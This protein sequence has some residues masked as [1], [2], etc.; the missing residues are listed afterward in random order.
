MA[1]V[2]AFRKRAR[3]VARNF[4]QSV[5]VV[6]DRA[7][8]GLF[9][10]PSLA[11]APTRGAS[12]TVPSNNSPGASDEQ[13]HHLNAKELIDSFASKGMVCSVIKPNVDEQFLQEAD[14]AAQR[15]DIVILDWQIYN[16]DGKATLETIKTIISTDSS[17]HDRLRLIAIYTGVVN[18]EEV[19][20]KV[21]I[22]LQGMSEL[23]AINKS[24]GGFVFDIGPVRTVI[25]AKDEGLLAEGSR[26]RAVSVALLADTVIDEFGMMTE[27][28][29]PSAVL[30]AI[31]ELRRVT[32][33]LISK[34]PARLDASYLNHRSLTVPADEALSHIYPLIASEIESIL[35]DCG[36]EDVLSDSAISDWIDDRVTNG[37]ELHTKAKI[38]GKHNAKMAIHDL[39]VHGVQEAKRKHA[40]RKSFVKA[41]DLIEQNKTESLSYLTDLLVDETPAVAI[42]RDRELAMRMS[43]RSRYKN[44]DPILQLGA[45]LKKKRSYYLCIQ[46]LCDCARVGEEMDF[47]FLTLSKSTKPC[48]F[49][50]ES[51]SSLLELKI[52]SGKNDV[53]RFRF[54]PTRSNSPVHAEE[55]REGWFFKDVDANEYRWVCDLKVQHA[56]RV[57]NEYATKVSRVGL[58]ESEWI[59]R[60]K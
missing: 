44:P 50:V 59:R 23:G 46:P 11:M 40:T 36:I 38:R 10:A 52:L 20:N 25:Y 27:G 34:F 37:V 32:H 12:L 29:L 31:G 19:A 55:D 15:A 58:T 8:F 42:D 16:D 14:T 5:V 56:Q 57:A 18:L 33:R 39:I 26:H 7:S 6:D 28:L 53:K 17:K 2:T 45:V 60:Q 4:L 47:V 22:L 9:P 43:I 54:K 24:R 35:S 3:E 13:R 51:N 1:E 49:V 48:N 41:L 21:E 30:M